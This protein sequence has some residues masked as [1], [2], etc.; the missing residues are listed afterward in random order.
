VSC[1][2]FDKLL[3]FTQVHRS[4]SIYTGHLSNGDPGGNLCVLSPVSPDGRVTKLVPELDG[5]V[6]GR[7]DLS[8]AFTCWTRGETG[9]SFIGTRNC[10]LSNPSRFDR[11]RGPRRYLRWPPPLNTLATRAKPLTA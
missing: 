7:F 4:V 5:G 10:L 2:N 8:S 6:F 3:F 1:L 11:V 9:P